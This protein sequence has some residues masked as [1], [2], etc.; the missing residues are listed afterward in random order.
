MNKIYSSED[1]I[2]RTKNIETG[3]IIQEFN[4]DSFSNSTTRITVNEQYLFTSTYNKITIRD[5][6]KIKII[7]ILDQPTS[8]LCIVDNKMIAISYNFIIWIYNIDDQKFIGYQKKKRFKKI[9]SV[10]N[11]C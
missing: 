2:V 1:N 4:Y 11:L 5:L 10:F 6:Q 9:R 7:D 3:Q 8:D